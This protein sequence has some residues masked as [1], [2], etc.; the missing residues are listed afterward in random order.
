MERRYPAAWLRGAV[1]AAVPV[2]SF[3]GPQA[4]AKLLARCETTALA[5]GDDYRLAITRWLMGMSIATGLE[6]KEQAERAGEPYAFALATVRYAFDTAFGAPQVAGEGIG[7]RSE[8][9]RPPTPAGTSPRSPPWLMGSRSS[10]SETWRWSS[11]PATDWWPRPPR[12]IQEM[13]YWLLVLGGL[14]RRDDT[15]SAWRSTPRSTPRTVGFPGPGSALTS[16][17]TSW[18]WPMVTVPSSDQSS[19][20]TRERGSSSAR[21]ALTGWSRATMSMEATSAAPTRWPRRCDRAATRQAM[22]HALTGLIDGSEDEWHRALRLADEHGLR[23]IAA[24]ALE[25]IGAAAADADSSTEALRL[26]GAADRLRRETGYRWRFAI[27]QAR[28]DAALER[29]ARTWETPPKR[30]GKRAATWTGTRPSPTPSAPAASSASPSR[31][32]EPDTDRAAGRRAGGRGAHE[33][34]DRG[35]PADGR[36]TVKTHLEHVYAKTGCRNRAE[37]AA[38]AVEHRHHDR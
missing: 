29:H 4:V 13:G 20:M 7:R 17:A 26:L 23:L 22:A 18:R 31:L 21:L 37:L 15:R 28:F 16:R 14:Y 12:P 2:G 36:G 24:D 19:A 1:S 25:A 33:P 11:T 32:G 30:P 35:T 8:P 27:E 10:R 38:V 5:V 6:L 9:W 34:G 3:R